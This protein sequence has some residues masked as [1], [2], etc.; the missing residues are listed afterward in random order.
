MNSIFE[1]VVWASANVS[2]PTHLVDH[3]YDLADVGAA[4]QV[5]VRF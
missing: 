1:T 4:F 2:G 3:E 5:S